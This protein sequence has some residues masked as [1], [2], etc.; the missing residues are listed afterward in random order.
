MR[1]RVRESRISLMMTVRCTAPMR[2]SDQEPVSM[3]LLELS[4]QLRWD[5]WA[6][7]IRTAR[8]TVNCLNGSLTFRSQWPP[9]QGADSKYFN[10]D[11]YTGSKSNDR[12]PIFERPDSLKNC[13]VMMITCTIPFVKLMPAVSRQHLKVSIQICH[14]LRSLW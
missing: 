8:H 12:L 7:G 11:L 2:L 3:C 9:E 4:N 5:V 6:M 10:G 13:T 1:W 14:H